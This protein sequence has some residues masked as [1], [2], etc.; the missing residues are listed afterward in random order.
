MKK[1]VF[2]ASYKNMKKRAN[3][4]QAWKSFTMQDT[5]VVSFLLPLYNYNDQMLP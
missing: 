4:R 2:I 5:L 3:D 1:N